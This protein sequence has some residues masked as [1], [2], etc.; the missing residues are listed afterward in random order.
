MKCHY[1]TIRKHIIT[2]IDFAIHNCKNYISMISAVAIVYFVID[3]SKINIRCVLRC[4]F[5]H[6]VICNAAYDIAPFSTYA[7]KNPYQ[8]Y[9]YLNYEHQYLKTILRYLCYS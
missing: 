1:N 3:N 4:F 5:I 7:F 2:L 8:S 9:N 6:L